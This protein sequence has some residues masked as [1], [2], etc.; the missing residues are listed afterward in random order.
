MGLGAKVVERRGKAP[1]I[2][3]KW[4]PETDILTGSVKGA[5]REKEDG[6]TG[7]VELEGM[8]GSFILLDVAGGSIRGVEVVVWPDVRTVGAL[9]PPEQPSEG[10]VLLPTRRSQPAVAAVEVDTSL[11]IETNAAESVFR[12]RLGPSRKAEAI[13]VA[14]G[15]LV[16]V[17]EKQELAGMWLVGVPP[18][19]H[20]DSAL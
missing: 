17:D 8:D 19:P 11:T 4:D 1:R 2:S 7:S 14:D 16:E 18:F 12:V 5:V 3:Y 6:L 15:L 20:D 9:H 13:R 10:D